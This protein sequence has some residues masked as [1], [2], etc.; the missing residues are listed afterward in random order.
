MLKQYASYFVSYLLSNLKSVGNVE[1]VILYGSVAR[2]E[3]TKESDID[4]FIEVKKKTK[5]FENEIRD[6]SEKFYESR[7]ASLFKL[8][9][10]SNDFDIKI[11]DLKEWKDLHTSIASTGI[12]LYGAYELREKTSDVKK[13]IIIFWDEVGKN[14]GA[15]LNKLYGFRVG[16]KSYEGILNKYDGKKLGKSCIMLPVQYRK[17]IFKLLEKYKVKAKTIEVFG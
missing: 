13:F 4:L 9:G 1:K 8:K 10:I 6:V 15:F 14:R 7:E 17:E 12:V 5:K 3:G 16:N 11:G 2:D